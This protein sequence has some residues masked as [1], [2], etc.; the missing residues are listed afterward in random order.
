MAGTPYRTE[1]SWDHGSYA[2]RARVVGRNPMPAPL[3][4]KSGG[5]QLVSNHVS[6]VVRSF[7]AGDQLVALGLEHGEGGAG[8]VFGFAYEAAQHV[9][10]LVLLG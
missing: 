6:V 5:R 2:Y 4:W 8:R 3:A 7:D 9:L 1:L 10:H